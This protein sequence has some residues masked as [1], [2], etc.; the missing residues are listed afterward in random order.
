VGVDPDLRCSTM[1]D[2]NSDCADNQFC[3]VTGLS[4]DGGATTYAK[5]CRYA[6]GAQNLCFGSLDCAT[7]QI[8]APYIFGDVSDDGS[9]VIEPRLEGHCIKAQSGGVPT[10]TS[11]E[12]LPC[13]V[14]GA[15]ISYGDGTFLCSS[16]C[17]PSSFGACP[18]G[19]VCSSLTYLSAEEVTDGIARSLPFCVLL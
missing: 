17:N 14:P 10:G 18:F 16:V 19:F 3:A 5:V 12:E 13:S 15:C 1:C 7:G 8:C 6:V 11:C 2:I 4:N 9:Q